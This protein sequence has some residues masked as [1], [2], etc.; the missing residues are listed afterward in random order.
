[1]NATFLNLVADAGGAA[2]TH[3]GLVNALG[4]EVGDARKSVSWT[5]AS[6]GLIRPTANLTFDMDEG[7]DVAGWRG[8]SALT[9]GTDFDGHDLDPVSFS[10]PGNYTLQA[11]TTGID[12]SVDA[13]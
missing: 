2:I 6:N 10:N 5:S 9:G 8:Y 3:I 7:D 11:S 1:M 4:N 13:P 12:I